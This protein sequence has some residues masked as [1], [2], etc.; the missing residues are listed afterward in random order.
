MGA[1]TYPVGG[2]GLVGEVTT[3]P[4]DIVVGVRLLPSHT[5]AEPVGLITR[6]I[7]YKVHD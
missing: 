1:F 3:V 2:W 6:V 4:P 7:R 5:P